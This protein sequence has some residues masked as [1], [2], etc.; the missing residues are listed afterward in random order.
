M[1][2]RTNLTATMKDRFAGTADLTDRIINVVGVQEGMPQQAQPST[3]SSAQPRSG[4]PSEG[5]PPGPR[6]ATHREMAS[7][8][9]KFDASM[10]KRYEFCS[11]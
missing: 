11:S 10:S 8:N 2:G 1:E 6:Q 7:I 9:R 5:Q 4:A 3:S